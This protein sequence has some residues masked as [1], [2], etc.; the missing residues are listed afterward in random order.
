[1]ML[2][3]TQTGELWML[4]AIGFIL[5]LAN[6]G[7]MTSD[8]PMIVR[9]FGLKSVGSIVGASSGIFSLGA[10]VGPICTGYIFDSTGSYQLAFFIGSAFCIAGIILA[11]LIR[12]T[13]KFVIRL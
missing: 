12:P 4:Y 9:L 8:S 1:M 7:N 3:L 2:W 10:A 11:Y 13:E 5:G 6:G